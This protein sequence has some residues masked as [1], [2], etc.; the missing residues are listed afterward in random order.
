MLHTI[1]QPRL[2]EAGLWVL[3]LILLLTQGIALVGLVSSFWALDP[4][5]AQQGSLELMA[6][7][8]SEDCE[9][10]PLPNTSLHLGTCVHTHTG[11]HLCTHAQL[12]VLCH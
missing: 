11:T 7:S 5:C 6:N 8:L 1:S 3:I 9:H 10:P 2:S 12:A 4:L